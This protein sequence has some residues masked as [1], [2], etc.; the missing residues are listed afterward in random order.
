V[1]SVVWLNVRRLVD[2]TWGL[3][4]GPEAQ[5]GR[6]LGLRHVSLPLVWLVEIVGFAGLIRMTRQARRVYRA[7]RDRDGRL[8]FAIM[9]LTA[10]YFFV[11]SVLTVSVPRLRAPDDVLLIIALGALV[12]ELWERRQVSADPQGAAHEA[13]GRGLQEPGDLQPPGVVAAS[14][15]ALPVRRIGQIQLISWA[16]AH[17]G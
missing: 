14:V 13:G 2:Q 11:V 15:L 8:G 1:P 9:P 17:H 12:A 5:D 16:R 7:R 4:D 3:N 10:L 6:P